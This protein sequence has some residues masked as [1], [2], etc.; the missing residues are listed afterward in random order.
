MD[1]E[2]LKDDHTVAYFIERGADTASLM[3]DA[4]TSQKYCD[5]F[6][7]ELKKV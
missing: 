6:T 3:K 4:A 7:M 2:G 1:Y 5:S